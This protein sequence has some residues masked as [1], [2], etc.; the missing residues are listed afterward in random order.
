[1]K[2]KQRLA[3]LL[4][5]A[6]FALT[7]TACSPKEVAADMV[8]NLATALGFVEEGIDAE[9]TTDVYAPAGGSITFPEGMDTTGRMVTQ[10]DGGTLYTSFNGIA[11]RSTPYFVAAGDT[12]TI[13]AYATTGSTGLLEFKTAL[14]EL[15]DDQ[16][17]TTYL[18]GTTVY[19]ATGGDCY[20]QSVSG[21]TPGKRYKI[22]IS[23]D[24]GLY[25]ITGGMMVSGVGTDELTDIE[26]DD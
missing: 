22:N 21:L 12:V 2:I 4:L 7:L 13:T 3:A 10:L 5:A 24:S 23:Y 11:N 15:S 8:I 6:A 17:T 1:M 25:F 19:Y 20:T 9:E 26:G 16:T 18:P 14:W